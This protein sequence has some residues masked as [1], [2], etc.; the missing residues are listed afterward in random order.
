M[1]HG[2]QASMNQHNCAS[3]AASLGFDGRGGGHRD[4]GR[5]NAEPPAGNC[6]C[7]PQGLIDEVASAAA[8]E[9]CASGEPH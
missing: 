7:E 6:A 5:R 4:L 8:S 9:I 3:A 2:Y 1:S